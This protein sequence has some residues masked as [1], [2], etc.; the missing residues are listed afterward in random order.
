MAR[1]NKRIILAFIICCFVFLPHV[2][3]ARIGLSILPVKNGNSGSA[4]IGLAKKAQKILERDMNR[5]VVCGQKEI[6][7]EVNWNDQI[8]SRTN[9]VVHH[10]DNDPTN[11]TM[12]NLILLCATCH[13]IHHK[14]HSTPFPWFRKY[15]RL[16]S[17]SMT[18]K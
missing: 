9:L 8:V 2:L 15:A 1:S 11:N 3:S 4:Q 17:M 10:I 5:C 14:S 7:Q 6:K 13:A 12:E 16:V 18:S